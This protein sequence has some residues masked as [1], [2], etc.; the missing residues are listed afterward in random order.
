MKLL[1]YCTLRKFIDDSARERFGYARGTKKSTFF[2]RK[3]FPRRKKN[4]ITSLVDEDGARKGGGEEVGRIANAYFSN[5]FHSLG[6]CGMEE[7]LDGIECRVK[8]DMKSDV[9]SPV[10]SG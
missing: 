10:F 3:P 1:T 7:A 6:C 9:A 4:L 5:L 8:D 2:H